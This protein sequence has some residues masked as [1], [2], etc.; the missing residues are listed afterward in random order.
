MK[1]FFIFLTTVV[2]LPVFNSSFASSHCG[3]FDAD[4]WSQKSLNPKMVVKSYNPDLAFNGTTLFGVTAK[5]NKSMAIIE[6]DMNGN[7][8]WE[9][10]VPTSI[11]KQSKMLM[12]VKRLSNGNTLFI[13]QNSGIY[14]INSASE[15][16]WKHLDQ[17]THDVDRLENGN[18]IYLRG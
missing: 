14:E 6:V 5:K 15:V 4:C 11:V 10:V 17:A 8:V 18:T 3:F 12:D 13:M 2:I 1:K 16:V 7:I 9:Y